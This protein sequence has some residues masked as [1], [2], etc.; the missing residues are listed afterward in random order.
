MI[1]SSHDSPLLYTIHNT[2]IWLVP[3]PLNRG[4]QRPRMNIRMVPSKRKGHEN[5]AG[6]EGRKQF[7]KAKAKSGILPS[8]GASTLCL[9]GLT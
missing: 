7:F 4:Q 6:R 8:N 5:T 1:T 3:I 9:R 2:V